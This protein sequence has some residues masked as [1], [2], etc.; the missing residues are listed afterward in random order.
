MSHESLQGI[1]FGPGSAMDEQ[2]NTSV[3][4]NVRGDEEHP[5]FVNDLSTLV[6]LDEESERN[7]TSNL[8]PRETSQ[9]LSAGLH[10]SFRL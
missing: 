9:R 5:V 8:L 2:P 6:Q 1:I 7:E 10:F 3:S 4:S